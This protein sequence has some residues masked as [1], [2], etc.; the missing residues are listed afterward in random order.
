LWSR[1]FDAIAHGQSQ[2]AIA[3]ADAR[4]KLRAGI[5]LLSDAL[6]RHGAYFDG[7]ALE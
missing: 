4:I 2:A 5:L 3:G 7:K 1:P 6:S